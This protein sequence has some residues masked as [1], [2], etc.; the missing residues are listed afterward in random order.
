MPASSP[1]RRF[2]IVNPGGGPITVR[3]LA[4]NALRAGAD[5]RIVRMKTERKEV[6]ETWKLAAGDTGAG[7]HEVSLRP[8]SLDGH[9][10]AWQVLVC[11][12]V[13]AIDRGTV[14]I[15]VLQDGV[16]CPVTK[17]AQWG[18]ERVPRCAGRARPISIRGNLT[19]LT[20]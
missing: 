9:V 3:L 11:S 5:F 14:E 8:R 4:N 19:F 10:M 15:Q 16:T 13:P 20:A 18:L 2:C 7:E 1:Q 12:V 17:P 6:R